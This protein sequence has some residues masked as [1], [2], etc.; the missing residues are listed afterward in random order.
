V[1]TACMNDRSLQMLNDV[2]ALLVART[3]SVNFLFEL[4]TLKTSRDPMQSAVTMNN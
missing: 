3:L 2:L 4:W 1:A